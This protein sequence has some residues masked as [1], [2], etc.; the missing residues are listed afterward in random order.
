MRRHI[1]PTA[2]TAG[3]SKIGVLAA[4]LAIPMTLMGAPAAGASTA[5]QSAVSI[6]QDAEFA[7]ASAE[8]ASLCNSKASAL[9]GGA[10]GP[11]SKQCTW[12]S[13]PGVTQRTV[14]WNVVSGSNQIACVQGRMGSYHPRSWTNLGCGQSGTATIPWTSNTI[15]TVEIR[16]RSQSP[17]SMAN[18]NYYF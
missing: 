1:S 14:S 3:L 5:P 10:W 9:P 12:T 7:P 2:F 11:I 16:V 15:A 17:V 8:S 18:V 6:P 4:A 13:A